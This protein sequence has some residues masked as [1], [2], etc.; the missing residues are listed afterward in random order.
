MQDRYQRFLQPVDQ[1]QYI[2]AAFAAIYTEL[3]LHY[4]GIYI[5][6]IDVIGGTYIIFLVIL[7]DHIFYLVRVF[8]F[9][10]V[11]R[12]VQCYYE[13]TF[14]QAFPFWKVGVDGPHQVLIKGSDPAFAWRIG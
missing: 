9:V 5:T 12:I 2:N 8:I 7:A 1:R 13:T 3:M 11:F 6:G 4:T 14:G 10:Q